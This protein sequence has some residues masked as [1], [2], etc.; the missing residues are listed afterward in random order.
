MAM[1]RTNLPGNCVLLW[2]LCQ[3]IAQK[4]FGWCGTSGTIVDISILC[5]YNTGQEVV[6]TYV[7]MARHMVQKSRAVTTRTGNWQD[8]ARPLR[9][10]TEYRSTEELSERVLGFQDVARTFRTRSENQSHM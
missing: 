1:Y 2:S 10:C 8:V 5:S 4:S 7:P 9:T 3:I 6:R